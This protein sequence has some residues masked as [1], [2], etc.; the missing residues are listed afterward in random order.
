MANHS[1]DVVVVGASFGGVAAALAA[2]SDPNV[3]VALLE[4]TDW[5]GGQATSQGVSR[6]DEASV[7][8][9]QTTCGNKSYRDLRHAISAY[10]H[11]NATLSASGESQSHFNPGFAGRIIRFPST[12]ASRSGCCVTSL[13]RRRRGLIC[14]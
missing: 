4:A 14:G 13:L 12:R 2:A 3:H 5:I 8:L 9:L 10:Y 11:N 7:D 1:Y 6:W